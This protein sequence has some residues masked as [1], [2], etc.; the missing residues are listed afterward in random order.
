MAKAILSRYIIPQVLTRI[1]HFNFTPRELVEGTLAG[2]HK[3]PFHGFAIE[4]AG[5]REYVRGDDIRHLDW[6]V[7][8]RHD[9]HVI[10]QYEME[11]NLVCHLM[12]DVSA[13]MRYGEEDQQKMLYAARMA[14]TLGYLIIEQS[15]KVSL[16]VFDEKVRA[17]LRASNTMGQ[18]LKM[19]S[20]LD[21]IDPVDKTAIGPSLLHLA[22]QAGRRGIIIILSDFFVNLQ[23]LED[24]L[25]RLR[26]DKHEVVLMQVLHHDELN[27]DLPGMVRFVGLEDEDQ[28]LTRPQDVRNA[29]LAAL[30][31]FNDKV[32]EICEA[33]GCER[34]LCDTSRPMAE[35]F[36]D[37][38]QQRTLT[39]RRW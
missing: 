13:S 4:F 29:Y 31:R 24:S 22:G 10:K 11:T 17:N 32:E 12:L 37:Y 5:H 16:T 18:I 26:Y 35:L 34:V 25:Q 7:Y 21:E 2:A 23:D 30:N 38:L 36:A 15:D 20:T 6:K 3:S 8:Y 1:E 39:R 27:F 19:T 9:R 33:N 28:F 14:V